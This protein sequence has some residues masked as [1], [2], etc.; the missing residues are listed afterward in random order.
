MFDL[1]RIIAMMPVDFRLGCDFF[2][3]FSRLAGKSERA[4]TAE[5]LNAAGSSEASGKR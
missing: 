1:E 3:I 2:P 4:A 5:A